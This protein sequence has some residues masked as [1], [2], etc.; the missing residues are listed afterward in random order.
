MNESIKNVEGIGDEF[1]S[2]LEYVGI[3]TVSEFLVKAQTQEDRDDLA[4]R[5]DISVGYINNWATMLDL[6]RIEGVGY[7]YAELFTYS[8]VRSV[9]DFRKRSPQNLHEIVKSI[10]DEKGFS[11]TVPSEQTLNSFIMNAK[12]ITNIIERY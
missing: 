8:G 1:K 5:S 2:K 3:K 11:G 4:N 12:T 6:T 10:N 7:Q 9:D